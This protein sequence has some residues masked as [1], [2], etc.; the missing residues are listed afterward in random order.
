MVF[1]YR[2]AQRQWPLNKTEPS[3]PGV[4]P[5]PKDTGKA[6]AQSIGM[7]LSVIRMRH[8][9]SVANKQRLAANPFVD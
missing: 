1:S 9:P 3:C 5:A 2:M 8:V 6:D 4:E 7:M